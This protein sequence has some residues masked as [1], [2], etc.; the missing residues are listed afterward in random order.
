MFS[1]S[2][3]MVL[4]TWFYVY[5]SM[6]CVR[7]LRVISHQSRKMSIQEQIKGLVYAHGGRGDTPRETL[8]V[9]EGFVREYVMN[10]TR[11]VCDTADL[12]GSNVDEECLK[13][14]LRYDRA[15]LSRVLEMSRN[16]KDILKESMISLEEAG[17]GGSR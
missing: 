4:C 14:A 5:G 13:F 9:I 11:I 10:L 3:Y 1:G 12:K 2:M 7:T 17:K 15:K 8:E 6:S 16:D